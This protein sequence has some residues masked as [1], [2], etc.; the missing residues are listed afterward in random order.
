MWAVLL[1]S[2]LLHATEIRISCGSDESLVL[3]DLLPIL[4][5]KRGKKQ[6]SGL[7]HDVKSPAS[8]VQ[9]HV[10]NQRDRERVNLVSSHFVLTLTLL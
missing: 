4:R 5:R 10:T 6:K 9:L 7:I 3:Q 1:D 8:W 2:W